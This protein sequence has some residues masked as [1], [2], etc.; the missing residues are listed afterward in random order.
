M[1]RARE[2]SAT[3]VIVDDDDGVRLSLE[4]LL[5]VAGY[6]TVTHASAESFLDSDWPGGPACV[7]LDLR[8]PGLGGID[9]HHQIRNRDAELPVIFLT[10]HADVPA[11]VQ[12]LKQGAYDFFE[13][14]G[15]DHGQLLERIESAMAQHRQRLAHR[16]EEQALQSRLLTLSERE[17]QV[18]CLAARGMPN[19]IIGQ[20]LGIS[21]RTVEVHR[22]R[23][24][25]K[26][27]LRS[28][29]DLV[30]LERFLDD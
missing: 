23:V 18:A 21:E 22:G 5:E 15:F 17:R 25:R 7:L 29:A 12:A 19:K 9:A 2:T 11:A 1:T 10:G 13:K 6:T 30:R 14:T 8:M 20:E 24:M 27:A 4:S 16:Q 28:A 26:L 3:V